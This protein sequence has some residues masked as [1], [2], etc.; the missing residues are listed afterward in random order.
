MHAMNK[1]SLVQENFKQYSWRALI[2]HRC[3]IQLNDEKILHE[4][5]VK[6]LKCAKMTAQLKGALGIN[7]QRTVGLWR[8]Y[9][10]PT[11]QG[12]KEPGTPH[13]EHAVPRHVRTLSEYEKR[14]RVRNAILEMI[15]HAPLYFEQSAM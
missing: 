12:P 3:E 13:S 15:N 1:L 6:R 7:V 11:E 2:E 9:A 5:E 10:E 4:L 14:T 8:K